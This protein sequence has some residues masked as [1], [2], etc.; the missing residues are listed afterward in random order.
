[1]VGGCVWATGCL[2]DVALLGLGLVAGVAAGLGGAEAVAEA[3]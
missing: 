2:E 1:M 3:F